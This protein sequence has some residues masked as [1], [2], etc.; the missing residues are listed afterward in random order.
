MAVHFVFL[1]FRQN[2]SGGTPYANVACHAYRQQ[3]AEG[4]QGVEVGH[5]DVGI[6]AAPMIVDADLEGLF[7]F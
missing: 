7:G 5:D 4:K 3:V 6:A 2:A 1:G